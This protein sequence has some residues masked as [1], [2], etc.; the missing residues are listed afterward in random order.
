M[1]LALA[2]VDLHLDLHLDLQRDGFNGNLGNLFECGWDLDQDLSL[3]Y[4]WFG[5]FAREV[6]L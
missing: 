1:G 4:L 5:D 2:E 6:W 3:L